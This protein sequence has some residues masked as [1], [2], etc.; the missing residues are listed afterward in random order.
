MV[1]PVFL[2]G[3]VSPSSHGSVFTVCGWV[4]PM[5]G[6]LLALGRHAFSWEYSHGPS[7]AL[8]PLDH[9]QQ[10]WRLRPR[11][12]QGTYALSLIYGKTV[13]HYLISQDKAGKYCIPEGTKFDTLWQVIVG[14]EAALSPTP[15][16]LTWECMAVCAQP[17]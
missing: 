9:Y 16:L 11:K 2:N 13:Y 12:E 8:C 10:I 4:F 6:C 7:T 14:A 1:D 15:L 17:A 5:N 3:L